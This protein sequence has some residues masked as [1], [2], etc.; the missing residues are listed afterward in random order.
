MLETMDL[1]KTTEATDLIDQAIN[2]ISRQNLVETRV[3]IDLLLDIR[4]VLAPEQAN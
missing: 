1:D 2:R 4:L 3:M